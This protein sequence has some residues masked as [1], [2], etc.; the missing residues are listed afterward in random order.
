MVKAR[1]VA[2][3]E[4]N[5]LFVSQLVSMLVDKG[6]IHKHDDA[7]TASG[8][9]AAASVPPTIQALLAARLDDLSREERAIMEPA[10]VIGLAFPQPAIEELVPATLRPTVPAHLRALS[11]KQ[12]LDR[13]GNQASEDEIYRFRNLMIKDAT[14]GSLL[15]RARATTHERFVAWAERVNKERGR[16]Q[17]FEEILGYHLEQAYRYRTE[18]GPIDAEGRSIAARAA[19]KLGNAG[20]RAF[21]RGD[22]PAAANLHRRAIAVLAAEDPVRIA[23]EVELGEVLLE[24]GEFDEATTS[25][26][27]AILAAEAIGDDGLRTR[28]RL[29]RMGVSLYAEEMEAGGA[30]R[31]IEE[32]TAAAELF[33]S[34]DDPAGL[35]R[36]Y[37][38]IGSLNATA[39]QYRAA[40]EAAQRV[41]TYA[42][43][44]G[45]RRLASRSAAGYATIARAG[46]IP[47]DEI[48]ER[49]GPLLDQVQGDRKA[50]AVI[51]S[52][53]AVAE[54]MQA[55]FDRARDLH[56][57]AR[58]ILDELGRS[59][60]SASTSIEGSRIEMLA[61]DFGAAERLLQA[62]ADELEGIGERYFRSTVVGLLAHALEAQG[63]TEEADTAVVLA[64]ELTDEDDV[65]SQI[66]WRTALAKNRARS[67]MEAEALALGAEAVELAAET[68]DIDVQG[69]VHADYGAVLLRLGRE[70]EARTEFEQARY[71]YRQKGNLA[72]ERAMD[73]ALG[74]AEVVGEQV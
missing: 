1:V 57:R 14:Y 16:E 20:S 71:L 13:D 38:L 26:E 66:L 6:L 61:G 43:A 24:A 63:R 35:A 55:R 12:F 25:L 46:D 54:A 42:T 48:I 53:I 45:D 30:A 19:T 34:R 21:A 29:G 69:D 37:R 33:E 52:I 56:L 8:D 9:L 32:A 27:A 36:A 68:D 28:G 70:G 11:R 23:L 10:S 4:G 73:A 47:A 64:R 2:S 44:A 60:V 65:E 59:V 40:G 31:A 74:E 17:E 51:L 62:D 3:S 7:W 50:E 15:K 5:P 22:L 39:G 58:T 67:G 18:L 49:C 41:V 72:L